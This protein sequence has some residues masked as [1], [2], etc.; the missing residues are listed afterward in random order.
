M[1]T[2]TK[3]LSSLKQRIAG[4]IADSSNVKVWAS[5][6]Q[7]LEELGQQSIAEAAA[8]VDFLISLLEIVREMLVAE[9]GGD[10]GTID[11]VVVFD[12]NLGA[13]TQTFTEYPPQHVPVIVSRIVEEIDAIAAL[14]KGTQ[15]KESSPQDR[16]VQKALRLVFKK[17]GL[18]LTGE[19]Y[20]RAFAYI[21]QNY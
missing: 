8:S 15:W 3:P 21:H 13:L 18:P 14:A 7:R 17:F 2:E 20:D 1:K 4:R 19:L 11:Q 6:S 10:E 9:Q 12:P 16:K 5:L